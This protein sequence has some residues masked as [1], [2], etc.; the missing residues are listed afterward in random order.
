MDEQIGHQSGQREDADADTGHDGQQEVTVDGL[1][2]GA[3]AE[4]EE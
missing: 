3:E 2:E 4:G 1:P